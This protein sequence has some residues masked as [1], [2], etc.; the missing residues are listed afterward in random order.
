VARVRLVP[1]ENRLWLMWSSLISRWNSV[2]DIVS[3]A[4]VSGVRVVAHVVS[5]VSFELVGSY[6]APICYC[7][8]R[9]SDPATGISRVLFL[10]RRAA[11]RRS[12][13]AG[14]RLCLL[15]RRNR[16]QGVLTIRSNRFLQKRFSSSM[17]SCCELDSS[18]AAT[19]LVA[20]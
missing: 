16:R 11:M 19:S 9:S 10:Y 17:G 4:V 7:S 1:R 14:L 18:K 3:E 12:F 5:C 8:F 13:L 15:A 20:T 6:F 2:L